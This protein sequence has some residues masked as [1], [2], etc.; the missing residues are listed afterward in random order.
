MTN[1]RSVVE[2]LIRAIDAVY[3]CDEAR[4]IPLLLAEARERAARAIAAEPRADLGR[5]GVSKDD[6]NRFNDIFGQAAMQAEDRAFASLPD[7]PES[8]ID[9]CIRI[10]NQLATA[11]RRQAAPSDE[12]TELRWIVNE[13]YESDGES[14][15]AFDRARIYLNRGA[16]R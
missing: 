13:M 16:L 6:W 8:D 11:L 2:D 12:L 9:V 3:E 15:E 1:L 7:K 5:W 4:G 10:I 14:S